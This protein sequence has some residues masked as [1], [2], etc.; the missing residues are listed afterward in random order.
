MTATTVTEISVL[1]RGNVNAFLVRGRKAVL[2]DT[3]HPG[4]RPEDPSCPG[5]ARR[6]RI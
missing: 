3:W 4:R 5:P 1:G 2:V 6:R